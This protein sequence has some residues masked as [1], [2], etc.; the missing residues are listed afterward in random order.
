M[1]EPSRLHPLPSITL[2]LSI[3]FQFCICSTTEIEKVV[4]CANKH[5]NRDVLMM[6]VSELKEDACSSDK[7]D[8]ECTTSS[9]KCELK[10]VS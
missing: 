1:A 9:D 4:R 3:D 8:S 7:H 10:S 2:A 6:K 5:P